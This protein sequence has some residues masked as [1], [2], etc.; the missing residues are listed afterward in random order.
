[1]EDK[2]SRADFSLSMQEKVSFED[3]KRYFTL[4]SASN[5]TAKGGT[6]SGAGGPMANR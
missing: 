1:M 6:N 4:N 2:L 5:D 3:M